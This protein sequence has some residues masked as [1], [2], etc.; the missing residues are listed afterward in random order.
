MSFARPLLTVL[1]LAGSAALAAAPKAPADAGE[2]VGQP[3]LPPELAKAFAALATAFEQGRADE[4]ERLSLPNAVTITTEPRRTRDEYGQDI[5]LP[6]AKT[7]F[8]RAIQSVQS[9]RDGC[10]LVRTKTSALHFV[11]VEKQWFL[12]RYLDKPID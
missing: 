3:A 6:F 11:Q 5:N 12:Y 10:W 9:E 4:I 2:A 7:K 8:S 1:A